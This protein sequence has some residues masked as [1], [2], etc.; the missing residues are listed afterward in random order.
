MAAVLLS[1]RS[2]LSGA[3]FDSRHRGIPVERVARLP[4]LG[5][6]SANG[7][8]RWRAQGRV[9][10]GRRRARA[11]ARASPALD[12]AAAT[13][14]FDG[15]CVVPLGTWSPRCLSTAARPRASRC[16][17]AARDQR[18]VVRGADCVV[19]AAALMG[20]FALVPRYSAPGFLGITRPDARARAAAVDPGH[21]RLRARPRG[22]DRLAACSAAVR[23]HDALRAAASCCSRRRPPDKIAIIAHFVRVAGELYLLFSLTQMGTRG[24]G[25]A[26][27]RRARA[28]AGNEALEARVAERTAELQARSTPTCASKSQR[29][30]LA[31]QR[32]LTPARAAEPAAADHARHR[33][34]AG[35]RQHLPGRRAQRRRAHAGRFR[36]AVQLRAATPACS[37]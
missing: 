3:A 18:L 23:G 10:R 29:A 13:S 33:R 24:H 1:R 4:A 30:R 27:A 16:P 11:A 22:Q 32:A 21:H 19:A 28:Q 35:S 14:L 12:F 6:G 37:R 9:L 20:L 7:P 8:A 25:A 5:H 17:L 34:A 26:H 31:E 2:R 36:R 15:C